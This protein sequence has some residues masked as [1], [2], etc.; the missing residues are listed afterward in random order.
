MLLLLDTI[1]GPHSKS[2]RHRTADH[3]RSASPVLTAGTYCSLPRSPRRCSRWT[4]R[5]HLPS[6]PHRVIKDGTE[7]V[8]DGLEINRRIGFALL[9]LVVQHLVLPGDDLLGGDVAH[10]QPAEVGQQFST[11]DV[12]LGSPGV[13]LESGFH[14]RRVEVHETLEGHVQIGAGLVELFALPG[15]CLPFG[16]EAPF[17]GLLA[18]AVPVGVAVDRSPSI[19]LFFFVD[20]HD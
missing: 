18:L 8:V 3:Y 16:L 11:D 1:Q 9:V 17:L 4:V 2:V 20:R 6:V 19:R 12:L 15:L 13:L 7:L 14:I 5:F 10:F